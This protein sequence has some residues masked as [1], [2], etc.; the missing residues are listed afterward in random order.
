MLGCGGDVGKGE[1][2]EDRE[3]MWGNLVG[4]VLGPHTLPHFPTPPPFLSPHAFPTPQHTSPLTPYTLAHFSTPH[5]SF[6][7]SQHTSLH[8]PPYLF[9]QLPSPP[10]T[11]QALFHTSPHIFPQ[12]F[13]YVAKL[14]CDFVT[15][16]NLT[17]KAQLIFYDN[18]EFKVLF[19]C[20]GRQCKFFMYESVA[21]LCYHVANSLATIL[22]TGIFCYR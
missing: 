5:T 12:S 16:I 8:L 2:N 22:D 20:T 1:G 6:L 15:L 13:D 21:K 11:P 19:W 4:C 7:T 14:P 17:G 18:R 3:E 10:P 9:P